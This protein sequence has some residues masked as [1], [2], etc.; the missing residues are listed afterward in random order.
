MTGAR[1]ARQEFLVC[2]VNNIPADTPPDTRD[3]LVAAEAERARS[4]VDEGIIVRLW[5]IPGRRQNVGLWSAASA[6]ELHN[7]I[8]SLPMY[9]YLDVTVTPLAAH[10]S[11]PNQL[12]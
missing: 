4:L 6:D 7:A 10:P 11:D 9:P 2:I 12:R 5:R 3:S 8:A 1:V